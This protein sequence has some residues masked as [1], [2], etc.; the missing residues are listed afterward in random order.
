MP[1]MEEILEDFEYAVRKSHGEGWDYVDGLTTENGFKILQLL[2]EQEV[3]KLKPQKIKLEERKVLE[4]D[5]YDEPVYSIDRFY[6]CPM[7]DKV[8]SRT[9]KNHDVRFCYSC[10]Q[11][12]EWDYLMI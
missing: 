4:D 7:C 6:H 12:V 3:G 10:G 1:D 8:L 11:A 2:K 5:S 9:N